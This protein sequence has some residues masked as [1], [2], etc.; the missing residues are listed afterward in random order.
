MNNINRQRFLNYAKWDLTINKS[1]YRT[2]AIVTMSLLFMVTILGFFIRFAEWRSDIAL[3]ERDGVVDAIALLNEMSGAPGVDGA[4]YVA[5]IICSLAMTVFAGCINHPLRNKQGRITT[6]TLPATNKEKFMWHV[7]LMLGGG[8]LLCLVSYALADLL[9]AALSVV[10]FGAEGTR[11]LMGCIGGGISDV[12]SSLFLPVI[13]NGGGE[14][15]LLVLI[16]M[17][18]VLSYPFQITIFAFGNALKY[19]FNILITIIA[20]QVVQFVLSI[21]FFIVGLSG[22]FVWFKNASADTLL[23]LSNIV[24]ALLVVAQ[25]V[26]MVL[27]WRKSYSLYCKAQVTSPWN[28]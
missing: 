1:F 8:F 27:M 22:A 21:L 13:K 24:F 17:S 11:S 14:A 25:I 5:L 28:K 18:M 15:I 23:Y 2:I 7:L 9:N 12:Y 20:L 16:V 19:K 3:M 6:L 10:T 26:L 4:A